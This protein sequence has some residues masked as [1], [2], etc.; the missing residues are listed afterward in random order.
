MMKWVYIFSLVLLVFFILLL[1]FG[2]LL[3]KNEKQNLTYVK[4]Q[5]KTATTQSDFIV[6]DNRIKHALTTMQ[7]SKKHSIN[8]QIIKENLTCVS[9][10]QCVLADAVFADLTCLVAINKI[11]ALRLKKAKKDLTD[12]GECITQSEHQAYARCENNICSFVSN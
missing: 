5:A 6:K 2:Y 12:I 3:N 1:G 10:E 9:H 7:S 11:G 4:Q 8:R